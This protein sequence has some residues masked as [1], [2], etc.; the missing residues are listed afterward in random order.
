MVNLEPKLIAALA[1]AVLALIVVIISMATTY[2]ID[3]E[4]VSLFELLSS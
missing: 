4:V 1:L 3:T 2:W